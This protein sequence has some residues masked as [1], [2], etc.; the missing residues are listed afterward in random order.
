MPQNKRASM[1]EGP[2]AALFRKTTEDTAP[3]SHPQPQLP[4]AEE[5]RYQDPLPAPAYPAASQTPSRSRPPQSPALRHRCT[6]SRLASRPRLLLAQNTPATTLN[7]LKPGLYVQV[8]DG[9]IHLTN[10]GG[11]QNFTA[12]Q[13]GF[14]PSFQQPPV[15]LPANPGMQFTPPPSFTSTTGTQAGSAPA[16]PGDVDCEV[17]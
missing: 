6:S 11:A 9:A 2:L 16:K 13:F 3:G 7:G 15:V 17:R 10:G 1:R 5:W 8:L 12:G 4:E 14:T